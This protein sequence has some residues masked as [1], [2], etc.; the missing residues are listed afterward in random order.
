[1]SKLDYLRQYPQLSSGF[2]ERR[3]LF[4]AACYCL[5]PQEAC[6]ALIEHLDGEE[7]KRRAIRRRVIETME[8]GWL[9]CHDN[10]LVE[11]LTIFEQ[12][13]YARSQRV[14]TNMRKFFPTMPELGRMKI[15]QLLFESRYVG[16][17]RS[18]YPLARDNWN[19]SYKQFIESAWIRWNDRECTELLG[20]YASKEFLQA[21]FDSILPSLLPR[22]LHILMS[23]LD[24]R[25]EEY[26]EKLRQWDEI[27]YCYIMAKE[28]RT[29]P[30]KEAIIIYER[31]H[32]DK[33]LGLLIWCFGR[34]GIWDALM[35]IE[36]RL[37]SDIRNRY[38]GVNFK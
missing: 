24:D 4:W 28:N 18:A 38:L 36:E 26:W 16:F 7:S 3:S 17:R 6:I 30:A 9:D 15:L 29:I 19:S 11:L 21:H 33:R 23:R 25:H 32:R 20:R 37:D 12:G 14:V 22:D 10:L 1:M 34:L 13:P 31:N 35:I 5:S 2:D 27:T 8:F